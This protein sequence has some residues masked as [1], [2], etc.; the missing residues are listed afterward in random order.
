MTSDRPTIDDYQEVIAQ[1][2]NH[3]AM[4]P[5]GSYQSVE[6]ENNRADDNPPNNLRVVVPRKATCT[7]RV[8]E[9]ARECG[10]EV[11]DVWQHDVDKRADAVKFL[12]EP[13][14]ASPRDDTGLEQD[15]YRVER[16]TKSTI[17]EAESAKHALQQVMDRD[18]ITTARG[19]IY[20][21]ENLDKDS[22]PD[23]ALRIGTDHTVEIVGRDPPSTELETCF[24]VLEEL[25]E[26]FDDDG[27]TSERDLI[28]EAHYLVQEYAE[29]ER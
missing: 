23:F 6:V 14:A 16:D 26:Q 7:P 11:T 2:E 20:D 27:M 5:D 9:T 24:R 22:Y 12:L 18:D 3:K 19:F 8:I 29:G 15:R 28:N 10:L 4:M 17:I 25:R 1:L 21:V 13:A